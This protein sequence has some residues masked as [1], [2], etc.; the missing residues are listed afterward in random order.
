MTSVLISIN[1]KSRRYDLF[2][3]VEMLGWSLKSS[4]VRFR[5]ESCILGLTKESF[6][7]ALGLDISWPLSRR[8]ISAEPYLICFLGEAV[9]PFY[10]R[11]QWMVLLRAHQHRSRLLL[12][13]S[14]A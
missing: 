1:V 3:I 4:S 9:L 5:T 6:S 12:F 14:L 13:S 8:P 7:T 11:S 10:R 2:F